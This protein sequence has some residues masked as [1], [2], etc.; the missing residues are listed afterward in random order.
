MK[1][2]NLFLS[3]IAMIVAFSAC[4][5][6]TED[7]IGGTPSIELVDF[8][9]D[10]ITFGADGGER[11]VALLAN[12][13][14]TIEEDASWIEVTPKS[15]SAAA[16]QQTVTIK[17]VKNELDEDDPTAGFDREADLKFTVGAKSV[18]L[19][20]KQEGPQ[21]STEALIVYYNNFDKEKAVKGESGWATYLDTF[22][23]W[24]N[25]T[26]TGLETVTY[27]YD[28]ITART[29]S[30]NGSAGGYSLYEGSGMNYLWFGSGKPYLAIQDIT[31]PEGK[32]NFTVS[33]GAERYLSSDGDEEV[34]NTFNWSEFKALVSLDGAKWSTLPF[35]FAGKELP[36][37]KWDL[38]SATF[39]VPEGTEKLSFYFASSVESAYAIDDFRLVEAL[40]EGVAVD[41]A[42]GEEFTPGEAEEGDQSDAAAIYSNNY[43]K[44]EAKKTYGSSGNS[45]PYLDQFD[46]WMNH[47]GTGAENVTYSYKGM[48]VRANSYSNSGYS[49]YEGSG[50][51][52]MFFGSNAYLSTNNIALNG[53][54]TLTLTFGSEKYSQENGSVFTNSEYHIWLS[55][56]GGAKW[57]ELTDYTFAGGTTEGRW[58]VATAN[59]TVPSGTETLSICMQVDVASAYR[60][61]DFKLAAGTVAGTAVDFSQAVEKDFAA[62]N[63]AGGEDSDATAI[64]SNNYD[65]QEATKTYGSSGESWPYLDQFDGWM[66]HAGTGAE[67]VT[68]SYKGMSARANSTSDGAYSDYDG[69]GLNNMFFGSNAYLST[70]NIALNG[71]TTLTLTFGTEKYSQE[72]GSVFTNSEYHIWLSNDGGAKWVE[73]T[74]YTFAGG[75]TSGRWN[76]A[77][78]NF[79]VPSGTETLSICM[80]VDVASSYRLDDFKLAAGTVAGTTVDFSKAVEKDFGA[81]SSTGGGTTPEGTGEGTQASPY[82]AAKAHNVAATLADGE[83]ITGVYVKGKITE[84]KEV[85][86]SYGNATYYITD[87][88]GAAKFYVYRGYALGNVK[89]TS[90]D[91]IKVGD[92]V[93]VYGDLMNYKGNS[94]QLGQ[95]NYIVELNGGAGDGGNDPEPELPGVGEGTQASPYDAAKAHNVAA[96]LADGEKITGV[97]VK[98]KITEITEVS[99]SYGNATYYITDET[100]A[101]KFYVY[102]GYA[103]GNV[104]FT[105]EDEIKVGDEVLVYGDLM[106]YKGNSPQLGQGNY[107]VELNSGSGEGGEEPEPEDPVDPSEVQVVTVA[108]FLAAAEDETVYELTGTITR[109]AI[110]YSSQYNN[111][112]YY[113]ADET[114]ETYVYRMSCEGVADPLSLSAGDEITVQGKRSS[115]NGVAQMAQGGKYISH[116]DKEAPAPEAGTY[117]LDFSDVANRTSYSTDEQIWEQNGIRL[118]NNKASSTSN[119]ADYSAPARFYKSTSLKIE[120]EG[121]NKMVFLCNSYKDTYPTDLQNSV[122]DTNAT[123]TVDGQTATITFASSVDVFEIATLAGQVRVDLLTVYAE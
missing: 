56:D 86:T 92:E 33:F 74:D 41:F 28:R 120:K 26:G 73:L 85:S 99:T 116:V 84:I 45:W 35:E 24:K 123:V 13:N 117:T 107:I 122:T 75:T 72:N 40:V 60:L 81:G 8:E 11:Q 96:T 78:A 7:V 17:V 94:P 108:D 54:T 4:D 61:D 66:N 98:G 114:G 37:G 19:T 44:L 32:V 101:A 10:E 30:G 36:D 5:D 68:Y 53:A 27:V 16:D 104:K 49:D 103:L 110:A 69:S 64:Y 82:D 14:W 20:V 119:V 57:V 22:E 111:I 109:I 106:N 55:N 80:Q 58:N 23:G 67:N 83:K 79:T 38:A 91:E 3:A 9:G 2:R 97:Y 52:N 1:L 100:G 12:R 112:T 87:A 95:G 121:M 31:L 115:Y 118:T 43:D 71:A 90:E 18:Y 42:A 15:G 63:P 77:T 113:I 89:F 93:L 39:K 21:G 65:K 6:K 105:S 59:F 48:S 34:D 88:T 29:N 76:V 50:L 47:A 70:N 102:R 25:A 51:N 46:G 62:G